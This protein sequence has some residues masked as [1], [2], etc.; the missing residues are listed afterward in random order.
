MI[1]LILSA[2]LNPILWA[3]EVLLM[4]PHYWLIWC[5]SQLGQ[6]PLSYSGGGVPLISPQRGGYLPPG[7]VIGY[8]AYP[9]HLPLHAE[10]V[11]HHSHGLLPSAAFSHFAYAAPIALTHYPKPLPLAPSY[12]S[13]GGAPYSSGGPSYS[14]APSYNSHHSSS[15]NWP[16]A[17]PAHKHSRPTHI[18]GRV[19]LIRLV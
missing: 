18:V 7:A 19:P 10:P 15:Y 4:V 16:A 13:G 17:A 12:N 9:Q 3:V 14:S 2:V 1:V 11:A 8:L 5:F 6:G